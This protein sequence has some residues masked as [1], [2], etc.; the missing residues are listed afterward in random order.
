MV[1]FLEYFLEGE[2]YTTL[3]TYLDNIRKH[4][5]PFTDE[6]FDTSDEATSALERMSILSVELVPNI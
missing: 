6:D 2:A 5:G 1:R 4:P 3:R